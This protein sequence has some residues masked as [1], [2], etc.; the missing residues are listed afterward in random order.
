MGSTIEQH[1]AHYN[2]TL[3]KDKT[4]ILHMNSPHAADLFFHTPDDPCS[5]KVPV[6]HSVKYL[7]L[8]LNDKGTLKTH[9]GPKLVSVRKSFGALQR[10]WSH[11]NIETQFKLKIFKG[12][13]PAM[14]L[15]G[16]HHDWH[17]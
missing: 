15:Y 4:V 6:A 16:L 5:V 9:I 12:I 10:L 17:I 11:D 8:K 3:N 7:G 14:V 1:A 2:M 13:F